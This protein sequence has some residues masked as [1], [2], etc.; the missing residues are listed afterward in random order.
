MTKPV[1]KSLLM[2][3]EENQRMGRL[4]RLAKLGTVLDRAVGIFFRETT[5]DRAYDEFGDMLPSD[6]RRAYIM[7][8]FSNAAA[9]GVSRKG[10][11]QECQAAMDDAAFIEKMAERARR[12]G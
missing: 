8:A 9:N 12:M 3:V 7:T 4:R 6:V 11:L 5:V 2:T 1:K 10:F